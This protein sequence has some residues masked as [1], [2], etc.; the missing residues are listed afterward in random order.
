MVIGPGGAGV[1][2]TAAAAALNAT[3]G[4]RRGAAGVSSLG[5]PDADTLLITADRRSPTAGL[6]GVFRTP[7]EPVV[8]STRLHLLSLDRLAL[9]E[10]TWAGFTT[11]LAETIARSKVVLPGV[12]ALAD[13][14][15]GELATLPGV[16]DFL[17]LRRIRDEAISGR[18]RRI[19]VDGSGLGDP[20]EFLR[21]AS[22]LSQ[23]LN[24]LWPRHRRLAMAAERPVLA[25]LTAAVDAIDRDCI[26]I[27]ELLTDPHSVAVHLVVSGDGR[28]AQVLPHFL[29]TVDVMG[30]ALRS[31]IVNQGTAAGAADVRTDA[32]RAMVGTDNDVQTAEIPRLAE[33]ID[34]AARLRKLAVALPTPNG[35]PSG[36]GAARVTEV[37]DAGSGDDD[38]PTY[39]LTW[40]Q[41]L[42]EPDTLRL[43]RS[44][45]DLLVTV[46]GFRH[47]VRL[48]SVLRRCIV[49]DAAW[50]GTDL[51]VRFVP[52]PGLWPQRR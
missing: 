3:G 25:Q 38:H 22:V 9:L 41:R 12:G 7:N 21:S 29:A 14:D 44:G 31:V 6:L 17:L 8:V 26:D 37:T 15:A 10:E 45:D 24:R 51:T 35:R 28:G 23:T 4:R 30:L 11:V 16:E 18:W 40:R 50:D 27:A 1:S 36:S 33:P 39:E 34:R 20:F 49:T 43:G 19:I 13:I 47:P 52:D 32:L 5:A 2:M 42:P 48:P 46:G